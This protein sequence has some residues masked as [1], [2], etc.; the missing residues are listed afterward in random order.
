MNP[1]RALARNLV[2]PR[3]STDSMTLDEWAGLF[4]SFDSMGY[5]GLRQTLS[6]NTEVADGTFLSLVQHAYRRSGV[7]FACMLTRMMLFSEARFQFQQLR[8]GRP[9]DL[10]G[11]PALGFLEHPWPGATTGDLLARASI[12]VDLAGTFY[13][14]RTAADRIRRLRPD[15]VVVVLGSRNDPDR[16][17][18]LGY[19]DPEAEIL[20]ILFHPGGLF[21]GKDPIPYRREQL[22]HFAPIPDPE[23]HFRGVSWLTAVRD[24]IAAD[25]ATTVHKRKFFDNGATPNLIIGLDIED[26]DKYKAWIEAFEK[27]HVGAKNAYKTL[28]LGAGAKAQVVGTNMQQLRFAETQGA[29]ETR[30][31]AAAGLHPSIIPLSEGLKGS[32]LNEGNQAAVMR[33]VGNKTFR[34]LWRNFAGSLETIVPPLSGTRVWYDDRDI[35][36]LAEDVKDAAEVLGLQMTAIRTGTDGGFDP[37]TV[38]D[39]VTSGDLRRLEHAGYLPVQ[40]QPIKGDGTVDPAE[41]GA[42]TFRYAGVRAERPGELSGDPWG[43]QTVR[44]I[45]DFWPVDGPLAGRTIAR[46]TMLGG[47]SILARQYPSLFELAPAAATVIEGHAV[48][49][50]S[51]QRREIR[52]T[53]TLPGGKLCNRLVA[54]VSAEAT[55]IGLEVKCERCGTLVAA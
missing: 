2:G 51:G 43:G 55:A 31:V 44:S 33:L 48:E 6:G 47:T 37:E 54:K 4:S 9:G 20:G 46:G 29:A 18:E 49:I 21:S 39:A 36:F 15:W 3:A 34:P 25:T 50:T 7:V 30:I 35:P 41:P 13:G 10:F 24:D 11:T 8:G 28:Y 16:F 23:A 53:G 17:E 26:V 12:D 40:V 32:S 19:L 5:G 38:V 1:V 42:I 52:C 22:V 14:V 45:A 27:K